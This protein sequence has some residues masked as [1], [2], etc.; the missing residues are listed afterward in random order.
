MSPYR[1]LFPDTAARN[2]GACAAHHAYAAQADRLLFANL[3]QAQRTLRREL[4]L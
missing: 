1:D 3:I 2:Q 4:T